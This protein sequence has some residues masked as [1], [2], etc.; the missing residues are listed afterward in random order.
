[1]YIYV[2]VYVCALAARL[3]HPIFAQHLARVHAVCMPPM[4]LFG[5]TR[6]SVFIT[7]SHSAFFFPPLH[8][9]VFKRIGQAWR[10]E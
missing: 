4:P 3:F 7:S 10:R 1:M 8:F 6:K 2:C 5:T 9:F